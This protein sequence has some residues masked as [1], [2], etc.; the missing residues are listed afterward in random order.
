MKP[1]G[2][3]TAGLKELFSCEHAAVYRSL[4][5]K[6]DERVG[7]LFTY[8]GP[9]RT[10]YCGSLAGLCSYL[11]HTDANNDACDCAKAWACLNQIKQAP[12]AKRKKAANG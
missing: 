9:T 12:A 2:T 8:F 11:R 4:K 3:D 6:W 10:V 5:P 1:E 7:F